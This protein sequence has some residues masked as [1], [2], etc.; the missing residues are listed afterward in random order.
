MVANRCSNY[1]R[2]Q[3]RAGD[4]LGAGY[5]HSLE[6]SMKAGLTSRGISLC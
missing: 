1:V 2:L 4:E 5:A 3:G 6:R